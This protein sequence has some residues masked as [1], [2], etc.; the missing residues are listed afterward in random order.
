M[1]VYMNHLLLTTILKNTKLKGTD[2]EQ[3]LFFNKYNQL[4]MEESEEL[5]RR[6]FKKILGQEYELGRMGEFAVG[7]KQLE[8]QNEILIREQKAS[9]RQNSHIFITINPKPTIELVKFL[10]VCHKI[11]KKTC[12]DDI[13]Y[14]FEQRGTIEGCDVGKGFHC[15]LLVKRNLNYK[16]TK[17]ITNVQN[18]CKNIVGNVKSGNQLNIK[19]IGPEFAADKKNYILGKNKTEEGKDV[20]QDADVKWRKSECIA[21]FYGSENII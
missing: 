2:A 8:K 7:L 18:S 4:H 5:I 3:I 20:K 19:V 15:H 10:T 12:F 11:A 21:E 16:P 9:K 14:V 6:K 17:C 1:Y 13:L